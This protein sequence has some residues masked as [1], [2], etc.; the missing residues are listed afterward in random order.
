MSHDRSPILTL[1]LLTALALPASS[2]NAQIPQPSG[3]VTF[4]AQRSTPIADNYTAS[5]DD[6]APQAI[7]FGTDARCP[8]SHPASFT[9]A[10]AQFTLRAAPYLIRVTGTNAFGST[11]GPQF[12][13]QIGA[14]PGLVTIGGVLPPSE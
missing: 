4:C 10:G 5:V 14:A 2:A 7:T 9:L 3:P 8:A 1:L 6:G 12:S 11:T 13:L